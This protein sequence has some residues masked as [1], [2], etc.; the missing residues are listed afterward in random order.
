MDFKEKTQKVKTWV[1]DNKGKIIIGVGLVAAFAVTASVVNKPGPSKEFAK[2]NEPKDD[3]IDGG[4]D[5]EMHFVDPETK[6]VLWKELCTEEYM[7]D[8][9]E[10]G[11]EYENVRKLN[12]IEEA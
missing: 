10:I 11:M 6:D 9:K 12:G 1:R 2:E 7:N 8:I 3:L 4:R 5:I